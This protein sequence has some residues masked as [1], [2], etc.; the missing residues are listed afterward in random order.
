MSP[1]FYGLN[2]NMDIKI[3]HVEASTHCNARC[4]LC[5]R[6]LHGYNVPGVYPELNLTIKAFEKVLAQF[7]DKTFVYFNGNLGDPMMNPDILSL[8]EM[9]NCYT[10]V[11]TNGGIGRRETWTGLAKQNGMVT[12]S[13]DGLEDTNHL[14]RQ[15]VKWDQIMKRARWYIDAGGTAEWKFVVFKH[16]HHQIAQA[17]LLSQQLGFNS[18]EVVDHGRNY[19]P[20]LDKKANITHWILPHDGSRQPTAYDVAGGIERYKKGHNLQTEKYI[21]KKYDI[22]CEHEKEQKIYVDVQGKLSPCCYQGFELPNRKF[23]ALSQFGELK[24]TWNTKSCD[25][26]C[27]AT[28]GK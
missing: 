28:C 8:V 14:Y 9:S 21:G 2:I 19:G 4:P 11:F 1:F 6:N 3:L 18:F 22:D 24:K 15:D 13:I 5:P 20:V 7:P 27:A 12:F 25:P 23:V 10:N 26:I 16:N 17:K